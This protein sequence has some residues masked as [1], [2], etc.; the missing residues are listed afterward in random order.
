MAWRSSGGRVR[1]L[2]LAL[3]FLG[4]CFSGSPEC[5]MVDSSTNSVLLDSSVEVS[6]AVDWSGEL[7]LLRLSGGIDL[8]MA[9]C[10]GRWSFVP[11]TV[12]E[13]GMLERWV[14]MEKFV[15]LHVLGNVS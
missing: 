10:S 11:S 9:W 1:K 3:A 2:A 12:T 7:A 13:D 14:N 8:D 15:L 5:R 6:D 4:S